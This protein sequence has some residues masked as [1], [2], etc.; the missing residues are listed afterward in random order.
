MAAN[1]FVC[2]AVAHDD[3]EDERDALQKR[4][5]ELEE[6]LKQEKAKNRGCTCDRVDEESMTKYA[7]S[8]LGKREG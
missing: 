6:A 5:E 1:Q 8:R 4:V 2:M 7:K 3:M